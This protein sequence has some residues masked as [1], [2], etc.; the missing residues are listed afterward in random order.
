MHEHIEF[1]LTGFSSVSYDL[2]FS[3]S[4]FVFVNHYNSLWLYPVIPLACPCRP[5]SP[6]EGLE[7]FLTPWISS[8]SIRTNRWDQSKWTDHLGCILVVYLHAGMELGTQYEWKLVISSRH[9]PVWRR[10][11]RARGAYTHCSRVFKDCVRGLIWVQAVPVFLTIWLSFVKSTYGLT[12]FTDRMQNR[13]NE[14]FSALCFHSLVNLVSTVNALLT[15]L[16]TPC[17]Y[18][19]SLVQKQ[20]KFLRVK[21]FGNVYW[22]YSTVYSSCLACAANQYLTICIWAFVFK[23]SVKWVNNSSVWAEESSLQRRWSALVLFWVLDGCAP[24]VSPL[25]T[26]IQADSEQW[27]EFLIITFI[28]SIE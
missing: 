27:L 15:S 26:Y 17:M 12:E 8:Y 3:Q 10:I 18:M 16:S 5:W 6:A 14:C 28:V 9:V 1:F 25:L 23:Q 11:L 22:L 24:P 19:A 21:R 20:E 7:L 4:T 13:C 2:K